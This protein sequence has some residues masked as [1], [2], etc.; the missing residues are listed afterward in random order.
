MG[1]KNNSPDCN[2][3]LEA[4]AEVSTSLRD[5]ILAQQRIS[6]TYLCWLSMRPKLVGGTLIPKK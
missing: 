2:P 5:D 6:I 1:S 4:K 3:I